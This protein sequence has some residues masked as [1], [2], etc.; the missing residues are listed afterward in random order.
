M[1]TIE[2]PTRVRVSADRLYQSLMDLAKIGATP[3][4]GNCRLALTDLDRQ[5]RD[6]VV[7]WMREAGLT[8]T[9]DQV[10]NVFGRRA[11]RDNSLA[12]IVTGSHIDTQP[13]GGKFDGC[14]GVLAGL[15]VVR[16]LNDQDVQTDAPIEVAIWTNEEGTRFVPVMMGSGAFVGKFDLGTVLEAKDKDG[17]RVGDELKAIGYAGSE[18]VGQ[19]P[20][21][22]YF[23]AHIEQGPILE[24]EKKTIGVV[25]GSLGLRWYDITVTGME[26]HAGPT[27]MGIRQDA[28][29]A[30]TFIMQDVVQSALDHAPH[31]RGTVGCATVYPSSRNVIPGKVTFTVDIRHQD[32]KDLQAMH[33][34]LKA[35]CDRIALAHRVTIEVTEVSHFPPTPF[36]PNLINA[37]REA[38][39]QGGFSHMDI[40]TGAGHDA[41]Y[42]ASVAPTGMIFVPCKDGI[43]HNEIEDA[44]PEDLAAG[45]QVLCDAMLIQAMK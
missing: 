24:H 9:I 8:V 36:D 37:V 11:G 2:A 10:G 19:H 35:T 44:S 26:M 4:G 20:V 42:L 7:G 27:P 13:T 32:A 16:A 41:V 5:G 25:T 6:L 43:S 38:A 18:P 40:V 15:E 23:E 29:Y 1:S 12:P 3:K 17:K 31:G 14:F 21:G 45:A 30:A 34:R 22:A 33:E 28:L 39:K